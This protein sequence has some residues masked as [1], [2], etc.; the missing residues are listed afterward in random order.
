MSFSS[1]TTTLM[2]PLARPP[3]SYSTSVVRRGEKAFPLSFNRLSLVSVLGTRLLKISL[4]VLA[5][6]GP[7]WWQDSIGSSSSSGGGVSC[8]RI[9]APKIVPGRG[10]AGESSLEQGETTRSRGAYEYYEYNGG[11]STGTVAH[12]SPAVRSPVISR[13]AIL[14]GSMG[15]IIPATGR[16]Q[17]LQSHSQ[18]DDTP[19][20]TDDNA[21]ATLNQMTSDHPN[22]SD[23][24]FQVGPADKTYWHHT[25]SPPYFTDR[26]V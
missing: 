14:S 17:I 7:A 1:G 21:T 12:H 6:I 2:G 25:S 4:I 3:K 18:L 20:F 10:S 15:Y 19:Q 11:S 13:R 16:R 5:F 26:F 22:L 23:Q 9:I 8:A 24:D